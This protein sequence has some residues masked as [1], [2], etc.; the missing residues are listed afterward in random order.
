[1]RAPN[2]PSVLKRGHKGGGGG[3]LTVVQSRRL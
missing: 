2:S 1:M 3:L